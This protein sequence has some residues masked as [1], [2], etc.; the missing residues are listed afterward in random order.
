MKRVGVALCL[1]AAVPALSDDPLSAYA[2]RLERNLKENIVPFWLSKSLDRQNGGYIINHDAKGNPNPAGSKGIVTQ[3]RQV[4]L[5]SRLAREGYRKSE[6]LNAAHH[7]FKFLAAKMWDRSNGGFFWEVDAAGEKRIRPKKHM[8]GQSFGLYA[9]GEYYLASG[10]K[11]ALELANRLFRLMEEK[12][13]DKQFGGYLEFFNEDWSATPADEQGYMG[14]AGLKLMNTHLHLLEAMTT[15]YR[16][17]KSPA[18]RE[19]LLE[20]IAIEASTVVRKDLG[21]CTD[22]YERNWTPRLDGNFARVSYG[23]DLENVWLII[24]A[25]RAAGISP[26]PYLDLFKSLWSYSLKHGYDSQNGGFYEDGA[27]NSPADRRTK[28]WWVQAEAI[29]S[30]L[31]MYELTRDPKYVEVFRKTYDFIDKYQTDWTVGEWHPTVTPDL[32]VRGGK[33]NIWKGGYHNGRAMLECLALLRSL[34]SGSSA[35]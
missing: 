24:D 2:P 30:A 3:A 22:K 9:L 4:W 27:F 1:I 34:A 19:R 33:A 13:Y 17:S 5:F 15:Y 26:W 23:H 11:E 31:Y 32:Q 6:T 7:G 16:A 18:A 10:S 21:A 25:A 14:P 28:T 20:L 12:A 35:R 8:Y 29:V